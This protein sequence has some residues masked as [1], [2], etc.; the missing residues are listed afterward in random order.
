LGLIGSGSPSRPAAE[1]SSRGLIVDTTSGI[2]DQLRLP[3]FKGYTNFE[4]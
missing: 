4:K 1:R 2:V 3:R